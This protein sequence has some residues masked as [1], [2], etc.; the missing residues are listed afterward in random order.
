MLKEI[1]LINSAN[2]NY[3]KV[4]LDKDLFFLGDN[5]SG[6][7]TFIRAIHFLYTADVKSLGIPPD[8]EGFK[9]YYF[10][11][12]NSYIIYVFEEFFIFVYKKNN[13]LIKYFSKQKFDIDAIKDK[14]GDLVEFSQIIAYL[15][16]GFSVRFRGVGEYCDVIHGKNKKYLDFMISKVSNI[17]LFLKLFNAVFNVDRAILDAK[18]IKKALLSAID[19]SEVSK[20]FDPNEYLNEIN[21]FMQ[22]YKFFKE[23]EKNIKNI[24]KI[25]ILKEE[26]LKIEEELLLINSFILYKKEKEKILIEEYSKKIEKLKKI[27]NNLTNKKERLIEK[28]EIFLDKIEVKLNKQKILLEKIKDL[29]IKFS[30][31]NVDEAKKLILDEFEANKELNLINEELAKLYSG[32]ADEVKGIENKIDSIKYKI[33]TTLPLEKENKFNLEK[34]ILEEEYSKKIQNIKNRFEKEKEKILQKI[35]ELE[36]EKEKVLGEIE[37]ISNNY[38][39][40]L[41]EFNLKK[42][43]I[44]KEK[45]DFFNEID[46]KIEKFQKNINEIKLE[47]FEKELQIKNIK[48]EFRQNLKEKEIE[49]KEEEKLLL[50]QIK[51]YEIMVSVKENSFKEFLINEVDEWEEKLYPI[52]EKE[53]LEKD[54]NELKPKVISS[55]I[56]GIEIDTSNLKKILPIE[57]A[58]EKINRLK[59][60]LNALKE[61]FDNN[62]TQ[63]KQDFQKKID[64]LD[65]VLL[66]NKEKISN[67][68][69]KIKKLQEQKIKLNKEFDEKKIKLQIQ[70]DNF[71]IEFNNK[72]EF[73]KNQKKEIETSIFKQNQKIKA[74]NLDEKNEISKIKNK[75][76]EQINLIQ[77]NILTWFEEEVEKLNNEIEKLNQKKYSITK[78][79]FIA[80]LEAK[81]NILYTKIGKITKAKIFLDEFESKK[82]LLKSKDSVES[83]LNRCKKLKKLLKTHLSKKIKAVIENIEQNK[84]Q[85]KTLKSDLDKFINGI[86]FL[87]DIKPFETK[88]K[89]N[90]EFLINLIEKF[91]KLKI[92][93]QEKILNLQKLLDKINKIQTL[94][95]FGIYFNI[96]LFEQESF[97]KNIE[98]ILINIDELTEFKEYKLDHIKQ[99]EQTKFKNFVSNL[100]TQKLTVLTNTQDRFLE[101]VAKVNKKLKE[102]DFGVI[103]G[104]KIESNFIDDNSIAKLLRV[105]KEKLDEISIIFKRDSLFFDSN[106]S[107]KKLKEIEE[108]FLKIKKELKSDKISL[109]DTIELSLSFIE[110]GVKKNNIIQIKNESSTGGSMLLKIAIAIS[111]LKVFIKESLGIFYLIVDEVSRLHS[112]NQK[113]LKKFANENGFKIIFVTPEPVFANTKE[114]IYYKFIKINDSFDVIE[115]NR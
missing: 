70:K 71:E 107:Y 73:L 77:K 27:E 68:Y 98:N 81:K 25:S 76:N 62:L 95:I 46:K 34:N 21:S 90:N 43:K 67:L 39:I 64:D 50:E 20:Y 28:K 9:E 102:V 60:K 66:I 17:E 16:K 61:E 110:N 84:Q 106:E 83:K 69:E 114:L 96:N 94:N 7:T 59:I 11:Y 37:N 57:V 26:I 93:H 99:Q 91:K 24:E 44:Q 36:I 33:K 103:S 111:I 100:I 51:E 108:I 5:G 113:K 12:D 22:M 72:K 38:F 86:K 29:E 14:N 35:K 87:N 3:A 8:K 88:P 115:L 6:K 74:L 49:F 82:D 55:N 47:S 42:E 101:L 1:I 48:N 19:S 18:S 54:I 30:K 85:I 92:A 41:E 13:E 109:T 32:I 56:L 45:I 89:E 15:K 78:N 58:N 31:K 104:I 53:L 63:I 112:Q 4:R 80:E 79:N 10:K 65:L 40:K 52:I 97:L 23:I 75:L 2:F 105:L